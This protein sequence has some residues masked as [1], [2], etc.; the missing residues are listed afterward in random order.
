MLD[1][2][3]RTDM[4][5]YIGKSEIGHVA[6]FLAL[7]LVIATGFLGVRA[8]DCHKSRVQPFVD[9]KAVTFV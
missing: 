7:G 5:N 3:L 4:F 6:P 1:E 2:I 8:A 9:S